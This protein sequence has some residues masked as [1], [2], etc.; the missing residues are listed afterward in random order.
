MKTIGFIA[1]L[2]LLLFSNTG[3][4][5]GHDMPRNASDI[6]KSLSSPEVHA[7]VAE[8]VEKFGAYFTDLNDPQPDELF[9]KNDPAPMYLAEEMADWVIGWDSFDWYFHAPIRAKLVQAMDYTPSNIRVKSLSDDLAVATWF[10]W[11][12]FKIG[13]RPPVGEHLRA[14]GIMR[15]TG[16]GW[17]M[18]YYAESPISAMAYIEDLYEAMAS[19]EFRQRFNRKPKKQE[20]GL[21]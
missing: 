13:T 9:D 6:E 20:F 3:L 12:E 17:K 1:G 19:P 15:K 8:V 18:V 2:S 10:V 11:A 16:D 4:A 5:G 14:T 7:A 21:E